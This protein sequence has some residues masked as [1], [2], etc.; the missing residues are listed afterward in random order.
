MAELRAGP[1]RR[2]PAPIRRPPAAAA[3]QAAISEFGAP[4]QV[5]DGF[6]AEI[7]ARHAR[8]LS[9]S[10]VAGGPLVG[11]LWVAAAFASHLGLHLAPPWHW[12]D[13][14]PLLDV[15]IR[16]VVVAIV[17]AAWAALLGIAPLPVASPDSRPP[18]RHGPTVAVIAGFGAA[19]AD[20]ILLRWSRAAG[21]G[22]RKARPLPVALATAAA[23]PSP[24]RPRGPPVPG[25]PRHPDRR[26]S[27]PADG[28]APPAMQ[29]RHPSRRGCGCGA[30]RWGGWSSALDRRQGRGGP[31]I[32]AAAAAQARAVP[33]AGS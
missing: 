33:G 15:G 18:G 32:R 21:R 9:A 17:A 28:A 29:P 26:L 23:C 1:G 3:A 5:A 2:R 4:E 11:L 22:P 8:R 25:H 10:L 24:R 16:L 27:Q 31:A 14:P 20:L 7:A 13:L 6:R 19:S 12:P 30:G